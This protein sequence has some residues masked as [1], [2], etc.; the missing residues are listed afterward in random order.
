MQHIYFILIHPIV[1][2]YMEYIQSI[3]VKRNS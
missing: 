1:L 3:T 2:Y